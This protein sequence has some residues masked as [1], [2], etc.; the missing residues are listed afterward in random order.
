MFETKLVLKSIDRVHSWPMLR[1]E[2]SL[3]L[4]DLKNDPRYSGGLSHRRTSG[5]SA[6]SKG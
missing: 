2:V 3:L 6:L 1:M 4:Y 5:R